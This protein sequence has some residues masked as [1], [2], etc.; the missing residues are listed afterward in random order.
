[1]S[2]QF[3]SGRFKGWAS[4][5]TPLAAG[6]LYTYASGTT[7]QKNA[8]TDSGLGTPCTYTSD[9]VGGL[10]IAL[11]ARGE[12]QLWLGTG[13]YTFALKTSAG[14]GVWTVDGVQDPKGEVDTLRAE[15][16]D[17]TDDTEG[18]ALMEFTPTKN[19]AA[20]TI[21]K[22]VKDLVALVALKDQAYI[23]VTGADP[24]GVADSYA[25]IRSALR[26]ASSVASAISTVFLG[27]GEYKLSA[28]LVTHDDTAT[29]GTTQCGFVGAGPFATKLNP[30]SDFTAVT[31]VTS[32]VECGGFSVHFASGLRTSARIGVEFASANDQLSQTKVKNILVENAYRSFIL[33]N[34]TGQPY[35]SLYLVTLE[36][37]LSIGASD[38]G[39]YLDSKNGST[40]LTLNQCYVKGGGTGK[41]FYINQFGDVLINTM[42]IDGCL[43]QWLEAVNVN[44]LNL[45]S[46]ALESNT[47]ADAA[48]VAVNINAN[49]AAVIGVKDV[50]STYSTTG[51]ARII[52]MGANC[53]SLAL[54][55]FEQQ[56]STVGGAATVY[57]ASLN[58]ATSRLSI[59]DDSVQLGEVLDN[60]YFAN[61]AYNG[62][63]ISRTATMPNYGTWVKGTVVAHGA[64]TAGQPKGWARATNGS[65][66]VLGTDWLSLGNF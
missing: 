61:V 22:A 46:L 39:F 5:G 25:A 36:N 50:S 3:T 2:F 51:N 52:G 66:H 56:G 42:A 32:Y 37:L 31:I 47:L 11:D 27:A 15:L 16:L 26:S 38:W 8:F 19:Y 10:Y 58:A 45:Q 62:Q 9:G 29:A 17:D 48:K 55:S 7:T 14:A 43:D 30:T 24:T 59:L 12:A 54:S 44:A 57:K 34:W 13:A 18:A 35:G 64:P 1:M 53:K 41:G 4:D 65:A 60:G 23:Q 49:R 20:S 6:R 33:R 40:T 21:G 28:G 63:I